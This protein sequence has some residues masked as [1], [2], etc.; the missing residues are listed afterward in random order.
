M[1]L[2]RFVA[3]KRHLTVGLNR[4]PS[5]VALIEG[6]PPEMLRGHCSWRR[7]ARREWRMTNGRL[8]LVHKK[9]LW[10]PTGA[11]ESEANLPWRTPN[12]GV[13]GNELVFDRAKLEAGQTQHSSEVGEAV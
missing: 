1:K 7:T 5:S 6:S 11:M 4:A 13:G 3:N 2:V 10:Y 12:S 9:L 8:I